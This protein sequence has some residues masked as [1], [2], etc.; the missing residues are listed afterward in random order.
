MD[1]DDNTITDEEEPGNIFVKAPWPMLGY[2]DNE[3][4]TKETLPGYDWVRTGDVGHY[5]GGKVWVVDRK[6][7]LIKVRGWQ[8]SPAEVESIVLQHPHVLDAAVIGVE[9]EDGAGEIP[10]AY[11]VLHPETKLEPAQLKAFVGQSLAKYK[12]PE[13]IIFVERIPKNSTGKILRRVLREEASKGIKVE[14]TETSSEDQTRRNAWH[15]L[16]IISVKLY[17]ASNS[18]GRFFS[19]LG[20]IFGQL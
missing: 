14:V 16:T 15:F 1:D 18:L 2:L 13:E 11:V 3:K 9:F 20:S 7:D 5:I 8:V 12:L 19:W 10:R 6:K 17:S 4:A